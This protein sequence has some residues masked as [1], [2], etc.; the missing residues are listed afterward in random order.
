[1]GFQAW[2]TAFTSPVVHNVLGLETRLQNFPIQV[3]LDPWVGLLSC[4]GLQMLRAKC[5][6]SRS[7]I[8]VCDSQFKHQRT[9]VA[10]GITPYPQEVVYNQA[11]LEAEG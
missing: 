3:L 10:R 2:K 7:Y 11:F 4:A 1:M 6:D 5:T 8:A 9:I